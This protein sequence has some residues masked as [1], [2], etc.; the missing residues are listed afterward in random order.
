[1]RKQ[2][3]LS[4]LLILTVAFVKIPVMAAPAGTASAGIVLQANRAFISTDNATSGASVFDGDSI[5]TDSGGT[6]QVR[7]GNSQAYLLPQSSAV[8]HQNGAG[9]GATLTAGT[10]ILSS[11]GGNG[12]S[13]LADGA[14]L[15]P[16]SSQATTAQ[17]TMVSPRELNLIS[18]K[19]SLEIS[20][21][22]EVKT[23]PEGS[24]Y[25]MVV[26]PDAAGSPG[27]P[28]PQNTP[29]PTG[30]NHFLLFALILV[31]AAVGIGLGLALISPDKP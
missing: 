18:Q 17:I 8:V 16:A 7:F 30:R 12:F 25:R 24:S 26:E 1:L 29:S 28:S 22:G 10:V 11:A 13:L 9:F 6:L 5:A 15:R 27:N 19:G 2:T 31:G 21:D 14:T 3:I 4:V 23:I 20:M